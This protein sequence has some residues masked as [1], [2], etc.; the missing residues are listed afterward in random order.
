MALYV[1][2]YLSITHIFVAALL[3][4][5]PIYVICRL[6][7]YVCHE[8]KPFDDFLFGLVILIIC[9]SRSFL[10]LPGAFIV[11]CTLFCV[12]VNTSTQKDVWNSR[13]LTQSHRPDRAG[14][15]VWHSLGSTTSLWWRVAVATFRTLFREYPSPV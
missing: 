8:L 15:L 3:S 12:C 9:V 14:G 1:F 4:V 10:T 11:C 2:H 7:G 6:S 13:R 5:D